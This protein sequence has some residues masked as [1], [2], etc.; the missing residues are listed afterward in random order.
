MK[1][2]PYCAEEI[3]DEAVICR[4]CHSDLRTGNV[5]VNTPQ[6]PPQPQIYRQPTPQ[7]AGYDS[8]LSAQ[9]KKVLLCCA[10]LIISLFA[11]LGMFFTLFT[12]NV[13]SLIGASDI[14]SITAFNAIDKLVGLFRIMNKDNANYLSDSV[15]GVLGLFVLICMVLCIMV[16]I[17]GVYFVRGITNISRDP[18]ESLYCFKNVCL[19]NAIV[20]IGAFAVIIIWN[21]FV[22]MGSENFPQDSYFASYGVK[23]AS[24]EAQPNIFIFG[25]AGIVGVTVILKLNKFVY[26]INKEQDKLSKYNN[27]TQESYWS[28]SSCGTYNRISNLYCVN[29]GKKKE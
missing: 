11:S 16:I 24:M 8:T 23:L 12:L 3:Q 21:L 7:Y 1:K 14:G 27:S 6:P 10:A 13:L 28:C 26:K 2:Y 22:S 18:A 17:W 29:C 25:I 15:K 9:T 4:Y 20:N 5:A 19:M